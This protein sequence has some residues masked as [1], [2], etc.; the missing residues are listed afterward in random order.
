MDENKNKFVCKR[1]G[2]STPSKFNLQKHLDRV[3]PCNSL[4]D[5]VSNRVLLEELKRKYNDDSPRCKLCDKTFTHASNLSRHKKI[6][7]AKHA[8]NN[9]TPSAPISN[10]SM[11]TAEYDDLKRTL[12]ELMNEIKTL[13]MNQGATTNINNQTINN[14]Q[15]TITNN[16]HINIRNGEKQNLLEKYMNGL[17]AIKK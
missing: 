1:C 3:N 8:Q 4:L 5:N 14:N 9:S 15:T 17:F 13:K 16:V 12:N 7:K 11:T 10:S 2:Y 6:C